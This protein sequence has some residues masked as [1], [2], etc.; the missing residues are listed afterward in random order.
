[1]SAVTTPS[2]QKRL[3]NLKALFALKG[4]AVHDVSTGGWF[5]AKWNL[6]KFCPA[7]ADLESFAA[8]VEAA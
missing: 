5:V 2:D 7:L 8:Q 3:A 1:M 4:F 6:T